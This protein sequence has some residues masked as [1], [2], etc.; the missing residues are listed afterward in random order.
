MD[1]E[2][3]IVNSPDSGLECSN[4]DEEKNSDLRTVDADVAADPPQHQQE[5]KRRCP[6][7]VEW[8]ITLEFLSFPKLII[9]PISL[10][11]QVGGPRFIFFLWPLWSLFSYLSF[12]LYFASYPENPKI[13]SSHISNAKILSY[14]DKLR[15][16][17]TVS[18]RFLVAW[19]FFDLVLTI[20]SLFFTSLF[21]I[22]VFTEADGTINDSWKS[23]Y[24][25]GVVECIFCGVSIFCRLSIIV[26]YTCSQGKRPEGEGDSG[27][28][29]ERTKQD[30]LYRTICFIT[31]SVFIFL[32][33]IFLSICL[34]NFLKTEYYYTSDGGNE[35]C[36]PMVD[37]ACL[38]P[39]PSSHFLVNDS[40]TATGYRV[41]IKDKTLPFLKRGVRMS[42]RYTANKYDGFSVSSMLLWH[43]DGGLHDDQFV[44]YSNVQASLLWNST[45]LLVNSRTERLHPHFTERDYV[46]P[47]SDKL[48]YI[49]PA[50]SLDYDTTY[51]AVIQGLVDSRGKLLAPTKLTERYIEGYTYGGEVDSELGLSDDRYRRFKTEVFP[52]LV[53]LGVNLSMV[54]L[55]W[56]LHTA[57]MA[58]T[59]TPLT[60][61]GE[62]TRA[63]IGAKVAANK[64]SSLYE[65][66]F[67]D[68]DDC[69]GGGDEW[70]RGGKMASIRYYDIAVPWYL[71]NN[72]VMRQALRCWYVKWLVG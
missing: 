39:Y 31:S 49:M 36:D 29:E 33:I 41:H 53:S 55:V 72:E 51:V 57:S 12:A 1:S 8:M 2:T 23:T 46:D 5:V 59:L 25:T 34:H 43:I 28:N 3:G 44:S 56:D 38:L 19:S 15:A 37:K 40:S 21:L 70:N 27:K 35:G 26:G 69:G 11:Q 48:A 22:G 60:Q 32:S 71:I 6:Q 65:L 24:I 17:S 54:Q 58:S 63:I 62:K 9:L 64:T 13:L 50:K 47:H 66:K 10:L 61:I 20:L 16:S 18:I 7:F 52:M 42:A 67:E 30:V 68:H 14:M 45:S 4:M